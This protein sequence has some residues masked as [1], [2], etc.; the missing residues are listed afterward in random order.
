MKLIHT[1]YHGNVCPGI[2]SIV[3]K[4]PNVLFSAGNLNIW[5]TKWAVLGCC[6]YLWRGEICDIPWL[7][8]DPDT[9]KTSI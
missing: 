6:Y 8:L 9:G 7:P 5:P 3:Y 4:L 1:L 2:F